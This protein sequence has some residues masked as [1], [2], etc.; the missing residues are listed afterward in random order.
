MIDEPCDG[1]TR[2]ATHALC[3]ECINEDVERINK[4]LVKC[5]EESER[6]MRYGIAQH[7]AAQDAIRERDE[8]RSAYTF[9][10]GYIEDASGARWWSA[11]LVARLEA[12]IA[13]LDGKVAAARREGA[14]AMREAC[15]RAV[16]DDYYWKYISAI[17]VEDVCGKGEA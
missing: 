11:E 8:A 5:R 9:R 3:D 4:L 2:T 13:E 12:K 1:C 14:E 15:Y 10:G 7:E 6:Q 16:D 17:R